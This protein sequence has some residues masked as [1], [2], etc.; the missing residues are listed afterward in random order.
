VVAVLA[1][2]DGQYQEVVTNFP[3]GSQILTGVFL[4]LDVTDP[5]GNTT[6]YTARDLR[7][8]GRHD[9]LRPQN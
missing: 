4:E 2:V 3:F 6:P 5:S 7:Q 8:S 1:G 9:G